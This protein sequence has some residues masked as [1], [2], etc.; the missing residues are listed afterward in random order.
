MQLHK[1]CYKNVK[2]I[3]HFYSKLLFYNFQT[4]IPDYNPVTDHRHSLRHNT[5]RLPMTKRKYYVQCT[6][7]QYL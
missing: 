3:L 2:N 4:I 5:L 1:L 7:Y 6:K